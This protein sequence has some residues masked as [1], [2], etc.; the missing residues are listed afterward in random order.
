M[1]GE[2]SNEPDLAL[3]DKLTS[4]VSG[5]PLMGRLTTLLLWHRSDPVDATEQHRNDLVDQRYQHNRNPFV[6]NPEWVNSVYLPK[7][8]LAAQPNGVS[9]SWESSWTSVILET[10]PQPAGVWTPLPVAATNNGSQLAVFVTI[11][12]AQQF[13]RLELR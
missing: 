3:T 5:N 10:V 6:D 1:A 12:N 4:I 7:L 2:H 13:F 8:F 9:V 11:T